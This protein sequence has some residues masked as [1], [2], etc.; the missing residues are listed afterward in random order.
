MAFW[1]PHPYPL[2]GGEGVQTV[3]GEGALLIGQGSVNRLGVEAT[4]AFV[5]DDNHRQRAHPHTHEFLHSTGITGDVLLCER[6]TF[7]R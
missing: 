4:E 1:D 2:P 3:E 5:T 7:L 6:D